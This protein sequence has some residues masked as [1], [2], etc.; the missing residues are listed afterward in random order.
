MKTLY[1]A[2]LIVA[3]LLVPGLLEQFAPTPATFSVNEKS[4]GEIGDDWPTETRIDFGPTGD[5]RLRV[6]LRDRVSSS[7]LP[8]EGSGRYLQFG[9]RIYLLHGNEPADRAAAPC[10]ARV[11]LTYIIDVRGDGDYSIWPGVPSAIV[12]GWF[13]VTAGALGWLC[14]QLGSAAMRALS[15]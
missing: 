7:R 3:L 2:G 1:L 5:G 9:N 13:L 4:C 10:T 14:L 6:E 12:L 8:Q 15:R 11:H